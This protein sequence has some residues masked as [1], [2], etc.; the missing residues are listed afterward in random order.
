MPQTK[1]SGIACFKSSCGPGGK[2]LV[3]SDRWKETC[4][5]GACQ[6][7]GVSRPQGGKTH[8]FGFIRGN[9]A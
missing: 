9:F 1:S 2:P 5:R 8:P 7:M 3:S 6:Q 4:D